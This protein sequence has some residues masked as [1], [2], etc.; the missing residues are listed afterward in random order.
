MLKKELFIFIIL[1]LFSLSN[2][3]AG[4]VSINTGGD[5]HLAGNP[6]YAIE[7]FFFQ[8]E[9]GAVCGNGILENGEECDDGNLING[10]GCD[11][12]CVI[13]VVAPVC[14]DGSCNGAETE[15]SCPA[16]CTSATGGGTGGGVTTTSLG[17]VVS[18]KEINLNLVAN[19]DPEDFS[20]SVSKI[21]RITNYR[22]NTTT[23]SISLVELA[24]LAYIN[25]TSFDLAPGASKD[26]TVVFIAPSQSGIFVGK[27]LI[28]SESVL[29]SLNVNPKISLFDSNIVVTNKNYQVRKGDRLKTEITLIPMNSGEKLDVTLDFEIKDFNGNSYTKKSETLLL[30]EKVTIQRDFD[31][32]EL[33]LGKYIIGLELIYPEGKAPSSAHFE[34][35]A[36]K[37]NLF[38]VI[39]IILILLILIILTILIIILIKRRRD[40]DKQQVRTIQNT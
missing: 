24:G 27:I 15:E 37:S 25:D 14:G 4:T 29:V 17:L 5:M 18:P 7:G 23:I 16:D 13:E 30:E 22:T 35:I 8:G 32:G 34:I 20:T 12:S 28:G 38:W 1:V 3:S 31:V 19:P 36:G 33:P 2:I 9:I 40:E 21:I 26:V 11:T 10:D 6:Q 39:L